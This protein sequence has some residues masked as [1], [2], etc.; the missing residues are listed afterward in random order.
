VACHGRSCS[1]S[2]ANAQAANGFGFLQISDSHI[3]F[4]QAATP[5]A[6]GTLEAAIAKAGAWAEARLHDSYRR[7]YAPVAA[8][9][10]RQ[11]RSG[12]QLG[13][14]RPQYPL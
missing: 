6:L 3:G 11:F 14:A 1:D 8:R 7:H 5:D 12:D 4:K 2:A 9:G 13:E 10:I